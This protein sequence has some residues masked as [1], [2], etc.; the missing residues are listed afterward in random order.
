M[1]PDLGSPEGRV[2]IP[3]LL[4]KTTWLILSLAY[5]GFSLAFIDNEERIA[6][7]DQ[8]NGLQKFTRLQ[9]M[10]G[11][12]AGQRHKGS[13]KFSPLFEF[14]DGSNYCSLTVCLSTLTMEQ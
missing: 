5:N 6:V 8:D 9:I 12:F 3:F 11:A 10:G 4:R 13:S 14:G 2:G 7:H 1:V